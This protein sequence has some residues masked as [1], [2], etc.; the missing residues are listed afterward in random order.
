LPFGNR[1][2]ENKKELLHSLFKGPD[3]ELIK[4]C[5]KENRLAQHELYKHCYAFLGR[6]CCRYKRFDEDLPEL[7][8]LSFL[9][10]LNHLAQFDTQKDFGS[11]IQRI[12]V[13]T[14]LDE[15]KRE[16][17][18]RHHVCQS[19]ENEPVVSY[20]NVVEFNSAVQKMNAQEILNMVNDLPDVTREIFNLTAIDGY[21]HKEAASIIGISE[22]N[23]RWHLNKARNLLKTKLL[24]Q[25]NEHIVYEERR[26]I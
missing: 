6:I 4:A 20:E 26:S 9:K 24:A 25:Q 5:I 13:N 2:F 21:S 1:I 11:W 12:A 19:S 23:S 3:S 14:C 17:V 7:I 18:Y 22:N 8:N 15:L 16:K 10:I